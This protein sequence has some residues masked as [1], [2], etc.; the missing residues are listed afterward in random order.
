MRRSVVK[1]VVSVLAILILAPLSGCPGSKTEKC[2]WGAV[3]PT[4]Q[5]C[6]DETEQCVL[7]DQIFSCRDQD[8][9]DS[10]A[11][12][13]SPPN[14]ACRNGI[15]IVPV[16]GDSV[17]DPDEEC[18]GDDLG[19]Q[20]C[21]S[22]GLGGG[23]L[24]CSSNCMYD[25]SGC[26]FGSVC[27]NNNKEGDEVCDGEDLDGETCQTQG[28]YGG[29]LACS[30]SCMEFDTSGCVGYC[31]DG[32]I[33]GGEV[34]D[35]S[36]LGG[37]T[38]ETLGYYE[39]GVLGCLDDCSG[40]DE[41]ECEGGYCGDE[42]INGD[43]VCDGEN[44]NGET[45]ETQGF[46]GGTLACS[47]DC[48]VFDTS[49]CSVGPP[50]SWVNIS[51]GTFDMGSED[52]FQSEQPVHS[53]TVPTFE[54][55]KTQV[56]VAQYE[57][58]VRAGVCTEPSTDTR[59]NWKDP[60]YEDHPVNCITWNQARGFCEWAGGR[61]PS[62][63]EWEYAARSRGQ[64][65]TYPWGDESATC[66]YAVMND[67]GD[68]G[69][70]SSRT[71]PVC[72]IVEGNTDQGLCDMAGNVWEWLED[73]WHSDYIGAPNDGSAWVENPRVPNRILRGG[74]YTN[75]DAAHLRATHRVGGHAHG[76]NHT[77]GFR[78]AR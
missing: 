19:G 11:Y 47:D 6:H 12:P 52:G 35:G 46:Y 60:G 68:W 53:V 73:D 30:D 17:T 32:T 69:C 7:P 21:E 51:G 14:T 59:C 25:K 70:G 63:A 74:S 61:L 8:E 77:D 39:G 15:C 54:I 56:T 29:T 55:S 72:S 49:E 34:C 33:N 75:S 67:D 57:D 2:S 45:C 24:G 31:G 78:C 66:S 71:R 22:L 16:C 36:M 43:E 38:C 20:T 10:C 41:S 48:M 76:D 62:E 18:D 1:A 5:V 28:F 64:N 3:C 23:T 13:G 58:C 26:E 42:T 9:Y 50:I 37:E 44:H 4:N 40:F 27:G 65:I